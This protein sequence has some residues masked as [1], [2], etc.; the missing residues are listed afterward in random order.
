[1]RWWRKSEIL[2]NAYVVNFSACLKSILCSKFI[3]MTIQ[4]LD[5]MTKWLQSS[6]ATFHYKQK[7]YK[8]AE[9]FYCEIHSSINAEWNPHQIKY[10]E[11]KTCNHCDP[12]SDVLW[13]IKFLLRIHCQ[14]WIYL[15]LFLRH[16]FVM[17]LWFEVVNLKLF[18]VVLIFLLILQ[19]IAI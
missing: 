8:V 18:F 16:F 11:T 13:L 14:W 1:M 5:F 12:S 9:W 19:Y 10:I 6:S 17:A 15:I 2:P 3:I 7:Q 4:C